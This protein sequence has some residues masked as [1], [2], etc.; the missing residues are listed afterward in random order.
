[1]A[2]GFRRIGGLGQESR[3]LLDHCDGRS[4][5]LLLWSALW[6]ACT[7][8]PTALVTTRLWPG[9]GRFLYLPASLGLIGLV[10]A[11]FALAAKAVVIA[12]RNRCASSGSP[13]SSEGTS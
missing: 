4:Q 13:R 5:P 7:L 8:A 12:S 6:F 1:M 10:D 11:A 9:F 2:H 3:E